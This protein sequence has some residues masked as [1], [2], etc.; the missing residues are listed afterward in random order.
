MI[1]KER[2]IKIE[3]RIKL[4]PS[5]TDVWVN[6]V[7][8]IPILSRLKSPKVA[9]SY[10]D[11]RS[12]SRPIPCFVFILLCPPFHSEC[13]S[14]ALQ[15]PACICSTCVFTRVV[16]S[17]SYIFRKSFGWVTFACNL[18][19]YFLFITPLTTLAVYTRVHE[20]ELCGFNSSNPDEVSVTPFQNNK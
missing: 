14:S 19:F 12:Q 9:Q 11:L 16:T 3:P 13:M 15:H 4:N 7:R 10:G 5:I 6:G 8:T 20:D 18:F 1:I 2:K 17:I